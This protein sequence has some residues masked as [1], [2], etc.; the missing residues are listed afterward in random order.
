MIAVGLQLL[1]TIVAPTHTISSPANVL[2]HSAVASSATIRPHASS[3][4]SSMLR[5]LLYSPGVPPR[6]WSDVLIHSLWHS[7]IGRTRYETYLS[8]KSDQPSSI[9]TRS[10]TSFSATLPPISTCGTMTRL[11]VA[12]RELVK[13]I[14]CPRSSHP[15]LNSYMILVWRSCLIRS[16]PSPAVPASTASSFCVKSTTS[17]WLSM[18][19]P[20]T[21]RSVIS[22]A[23]VSMSL[24]N[25]WASSEC[26]TERISSSFTLRVTLTRS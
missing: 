10:M 2:T 20:T 16:P 7:S 3:Q 18:T 15:D 5:S 14:T 22:S 21:R 9:A 26:T 13:P 24:S 25:G 4:L 23:P 11:R 6:F 12:S 17:P 1:H 8:E 19:P